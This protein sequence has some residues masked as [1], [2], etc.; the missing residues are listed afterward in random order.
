M[1]AGISHWNGEQSFFFF[2]LSLSNNKKMNFYINHPPPHTLTTSNL[3]L[4]TSLL[5]ISTLILNRTK[6]RILSDMSFTIISGNLVRNSV[7]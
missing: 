5:E 6:K 4:N 7:G 1:L 3:L 2:S